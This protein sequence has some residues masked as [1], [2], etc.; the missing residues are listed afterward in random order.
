MNYIV[1]YI[2]LFKIFSTQYYV[3]KYL[4]VLCVQKSTFYSVVCHHHVSSLHS[5]SD[6]CLDSLKFLHWTGRSQK[7]GHFQMIGIQNSAGGRIEEHT[8]KISVCACTCAHIYQQ[9]DISIDNGE[10]R[11]I[12]A[13]MHTHLSYEL[14]GILPEVWLIQV[15]GI[16]VFAGQKGKLGGV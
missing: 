9:R 6:E 16:P 15:H 2:S 1:Q 7:T 12:H 8:L 13:C 4:S 14:A 3:L 11:D 5:S 10:S